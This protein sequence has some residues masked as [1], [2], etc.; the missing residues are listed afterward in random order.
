[1]SN[2]TCERAAILHKL[3]QRDR[4]AALSRE[5]YRG[6]AE[7]QLDLQALWYRSWLF[8][9]HECELAGPGAYLT[10]Q[11]GDYPILVLRDGN[12]VIRAFHNSCR[13]RGSRVCSAASGTVSRLVCPYH[14][15]TYRLDGTLLGAR[16]MPA[17]FARQHS[18][19]KPVQCVAFGGYVWVCLNEEPPDLEEFRG[20]VEPYLLP[21]RLGDAKVVFASTIVE[22]ANWKLVWENNRECYHCPGNHPELCRTFPATPTVAGPEAVAGNE[23]LQRRW[24]QWEAAG[25]PS[26]FHLSRTGQSR[27][28][29]MPLLDDAVSYTLDG[30]AAV[31]RPL[32]DS[33]P[34]GDVGALLMFHYPS[35]WN[36]VLADHAISFRVL[37]LS[38]TETQ[39]TT[40][41]LVHQDAEP[42][43]DFDLKKLTEVWLA[44][45]EED[46][47]VCEE[48]QCGVNSPAYSPAGY[49]PLQEA[50]VMQFVDWYC[51]RL[52][53]YLEG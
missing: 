13:H 27:I 39:L 9:A 11:I 8:L 21:H 5:F 47:R 22:R 23:R 43:V 49:S 37:P 44:T 38:P 32:S 16:D 28:T 18:G 53:A 33:V 48:N 34:R 1:M 15:W 36:H 3:A 4:A 30:S 40:R 25:L 31:G 42:G 2:N 51:G 45:N 14:Q 35:T 52:R 46:R 19:L 26:R 6:E 17:D 29:R 20:Q 50:G 7:Y 41:W 12:G 10:A 24:E